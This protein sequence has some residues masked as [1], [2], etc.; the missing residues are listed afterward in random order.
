MPFCYIMFILF[1]YINMFKASSLEVKYTENS[2]MV[3]LDFSRHCQVS[4]M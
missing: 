3:D 1:Y 4:D 2:T